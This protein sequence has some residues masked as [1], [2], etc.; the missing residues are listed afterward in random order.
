MEHYDFFTSFEDDMRITASHIE[1]FMDMTQK[2]DLIKEASEQGS[3]K[4]KIS[5]SID[6]P[7]TLTQLGTHALLI[8][9]LIP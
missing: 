4:K 3:V 7:M 6:G 1:A 2:I 8:S 9:K 5:D